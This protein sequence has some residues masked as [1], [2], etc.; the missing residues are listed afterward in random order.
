MVADERVELRVGDA[1]S[2]GL[3][4]ECATNVN[5]RLVLGSCREVYGDHIGLFRVI[6][7]YIGGL[8]RGCVGI[9]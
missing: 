4:D 5:L 8:Y 7:G 1:E 2:T 9:I 3:P 6:W